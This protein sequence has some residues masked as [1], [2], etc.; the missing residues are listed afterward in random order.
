[1]TRIIVENIIWDSWNREHIGKHGVQPAEVEEAGKQIIYHKR[2]YG[3]RYLLIG[4]SG[5]RLLGLVLKRIEPKT[6][7]LVTA[8]D[9]SKKERRDVYEKQKK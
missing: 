7:Y 6:Y 9:A 8:R 5:F 2:T 1:M 4:R 3:G